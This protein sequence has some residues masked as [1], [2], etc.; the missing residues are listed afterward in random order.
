MVSDSM[1]TQAASK[2]KSATGDSSDDDDNPT[3][4]AADIT[5]FLA[6]RTGAITTAVTAATTST[7][8]ASKRS[9]HTAINPFDTQAMNFDSRDGKGQWYKCMDKTGEWKRIAIVTANAKLFTDLI[10]D[11]TTTFGFCSIIN[12]PTSGAGTVDENP[13]RVS[14]VDVWSA[15]LKEAINLLLQNHLVTL[16]HV[17]AYYG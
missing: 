3:L 1:K 9:I 16:D 7:R 6:A 13:R 17:Q 15:E 2:K 12:V 8:T 14:G 4:P 11:R 10:E 5:A